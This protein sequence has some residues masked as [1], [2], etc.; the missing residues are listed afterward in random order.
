MNKNIFQDITP[1][2]KLP[3]KAKEDVLNSIETAKL[4][5]DF[6]DLIAPKRVALNLNVLKQTQDNNQKPTTKE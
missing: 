3:T 1:K 2:E 5:L 6:W 4:L